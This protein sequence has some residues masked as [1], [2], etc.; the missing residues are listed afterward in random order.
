MESREVIPMMTILEERKSTLPIDI[1]TSEIHCT[2][3][4]DNN[5]CIE[6][7]KYPK[8]RPRTKNIDYNT[9]KVKIT[10]KYIDTY[11]QVAGVYKKVLLEAQ[12]KYRINY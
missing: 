2:I 11:N 12:F 1:D 6:L 5:S 3:I 4:K 8:M 10:S 9:S 7:V